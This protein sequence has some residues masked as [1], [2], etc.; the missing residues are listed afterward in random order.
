ML[1]NSSVPPTHCMAFR[2]CPSS[3]DERT[4]AVSGSSSVATVSAIGFR[5]AAPQLNASNASAAVTRPR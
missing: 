5:R 1:S 3:N 2:C 4:T